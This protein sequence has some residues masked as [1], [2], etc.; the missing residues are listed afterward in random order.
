M[1]TKLILY[2]HKWEL[3]RD[4]DERY[5]QTEKGAGG[6]KYCLVLK[7]SFMLGWEGDSER[8]FASDNPLPNPSGTCLT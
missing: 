2:H 5:K 4:T 8:G 1:D 6:E 7:Q 3:G